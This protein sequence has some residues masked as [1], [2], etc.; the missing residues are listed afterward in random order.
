M[1]VG[2]WRGGPLEYS[3]IGSHRLVTKSLCPFRLRILSLSM[4]YAYISMSFLAQAALS[5]KFSLAFDGS[6]IIRNEN[7][8]RK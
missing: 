6:F 1:E 5:E 3:D 8:D 7:S 4:T 2:G